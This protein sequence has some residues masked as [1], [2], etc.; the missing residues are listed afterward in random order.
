MI[1][2]ADRALA[3]APAE[4]IGTARARRRDAIRRLRA[5]G[6][7]CGDRVEGG[8]PGSA[9]WDHGCVVG[10]TPEGLVDVAWRGGACR[11]GAPHGDLRPYDGTPKWGPSV[12]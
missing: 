1:D 8:A 10:V 7:A 6:L 3:D 11:A 12:E 4:A 9:D 2:E 5:V